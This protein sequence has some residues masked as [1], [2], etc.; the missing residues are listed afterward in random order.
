[1]LTD[2]VWCFAK[3]RELKKSNHPAARACILECECWEFVCLKTFQNK[4]V[5]ELV[6]PCKNGN[7][8]GNFCGPVSH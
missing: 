2:G 7:N 6:P 5:N 3:T 1:M 4:N 8:N